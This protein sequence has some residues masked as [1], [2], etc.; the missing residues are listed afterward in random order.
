MTDYE[1]MKTAVRNLFKQKINI[2][3]LINNSGVAHGGLFQMTPVSK[4]KEVF[5]I[6][7]F[8]HMELTQL[9]LRT[10]T[11]A[12]NGNIVNIA[13]IAGLDLA[14]GN[15]AYGVSKAALAA[16]TKTLASECIKYNIRVNAVAPGLTNTNMAELMEE[17]AKEEMVSASAMNRL[18]KPEEIANAVLFLASEKSSFINGQIIRVDGGS[19]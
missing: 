9:I 2:D 16:W 3:V 12:K 8:S 10:M 17:K 19:R 6:N 4:I 15:C 5:E 11:R 1:A 7:L 13:S 14:Q 18:A